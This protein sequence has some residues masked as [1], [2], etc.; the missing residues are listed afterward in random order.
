MWTA[1]TLVRLCGW[2]G[3][4]KSSL[5]AQPHCWFCHVAAQMSWDTAKPTKWPMS[6][7]RTKPTK[8]LCTQRGPWSAWA[9]T[10][11]DL[12]LRYALNGQLFPAK[13]PSFLHV[14]S[15][16]SDQTGQVNLRWVQMLFCW[17]CCATA[18]ICPQRSGLPLHVRS[19]I[20]A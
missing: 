12:S 2:P 7:C 6:H 19:L 11:S 17:F 3:W 20:R 9:S 5:V 4:S 14:D 13:G 16:Y 15:G 8:Y 18:H 1:K 10:Q